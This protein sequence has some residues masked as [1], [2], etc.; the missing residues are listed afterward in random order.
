VLAELDD[1]AGALE[2]AIGYGGS[3][4]DLEIRAARLQKI[5]GRWPPYPPG[6]TRTS[7]CPLRKR[8]PAGR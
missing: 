8:L 2:R 5:A 7:A 6:S 3:P 1:I 4:E